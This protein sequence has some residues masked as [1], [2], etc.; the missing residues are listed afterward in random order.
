MDLSFVSDQ[1]VLRWLATGT[2]LCLV[3]PALAC[4][5]L[6]SRRVMQFTFGLMVFSVCSPD[7]FG[8]SFLS[9]PE[10]R[11]AI[12]GFDLYLADFCALSLAFV[13]IFQAKTRHV[14]WAV[15]LF[16]PYVLFLLVG[17]LSWGAAVPSLVVPDTRVLE[18][19]TVTPPPYSIFDTSLYPWFEIWRVV[20]G[21]LVFWVTVNFVR[22]EK[23]LQT[24]VWA[25]LAMAAYLTLQALRERYFYGSYRVSTNLLHPNDFAIFCAMLSAVFLPLAI[26]QKNIWKSLI[27]GVATLAMGGCIVMTVS[28]SALAIYLAIALL[29][30]LILLP[31]YFSG[32]NLAYLGAALILMGAGAARAWD[33]LE[34]RF[35]RLASVERSMNER[36]MFNKEAVLMVRDHPF[37]VGLGNF[38][39]WSWEKYAELVDADLE[40]G[41]PAHNIWYLTY[42][43]MGF[44][45]VA[46]LLAIWFR[47]YQLSLVG[48][49]RGLED[50][51][52]VLLL[53]IVLATVALH[54]QSLFHFSYRNGG[55]YH[56]LQ[57]FVGIL[58]ALILLQ[59]EQRRAT[60]A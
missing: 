42:G 48:W 46:A 49:W 2:L 32:R 50:F 35:F 14:R 41:V 51:P 20:R 26:Q 36:D 4:L 25:L 16:W 58:V 7:D 44:A 18:T 60:L 30:V 3:V 57:V 17:L 38:S 31:R 45:G 43:E 54:L 53:G 23:D 12:R 22:D 15:P 5:C 11:A 21:L 19:I 56:L 27:L 6:V 10:Y 47:T 37:G 9:R 28:R 52:R 34:N 39:A 33:T 8:V 40:P 29:T 13:I 1:D 24:F 59:K 55:I